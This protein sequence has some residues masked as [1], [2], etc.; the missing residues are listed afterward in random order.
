MTTLATDTPRA[1]ELGNNNHIPVIGSDIIYEGAAVGVVLASGHARPLTSVDI[2][3]GFAVAQAD[4]STGS[5]ADINVEVKKRGQISLA[6]SGA[7]ITDLDQPV[8]AT[9]DNVFAFTPVGGVFVG[10]VKRFVSSGVVIVEYDT[11]TITDPWAGYVVEALGASTKT[12]DAL[13][14]GKA[15]FVTV[16]SVITLPATAT[17]LK[18]VALVC[19]GA[20][21]TVQ[22][23]ASPAAA[24]KIV[25]AD[26]AGTDD[27]DLVNTQA[28]AQ[29]GDF[30]VLDAGH[31]DGYN[32]TAQAGTWA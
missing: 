9:D 7:V 12:L 31:T 28:T 13:D 30:V 2:F 29:R 32:V 17:A 16:D 19:M 26:S 18:N 1:Y 20:Y 4:N 11:E 21:G 15:I 14:S 3:A 23:S 25:S 10:M 6:V 22:I 24:D 27:T 8:Y 5:A